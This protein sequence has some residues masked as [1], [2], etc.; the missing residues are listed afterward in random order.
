MKTLVEIMNTSQTAEAAFLYLSLRERHR[1]EP[2]RIA[3]LGKAM[4]EEGCEVVRND[5]YQLF[6]DLEAFGAGK[7]LT[8]RTVPFHF[9]WSENYIELANKAIAAAGGLKPDVIVARPKAR[10]LTT[11]IRRPAILPPS[12]RE[13]VFVMPNG[14][15]VRLE[16]SRQ[17]ADKDL[18][19]L[20]TKLRNLIA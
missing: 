6:K 8:S 5:L 9:T 12:N 17:T 14:S 2:M 4:R 10:P 3:R 15:L 11:R 19:D 16:I 7:L 1:K 18:T 13:V 20:A